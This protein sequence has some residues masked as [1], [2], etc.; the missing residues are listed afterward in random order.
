MLLL[1]V[2]LIL[3][4]CLKTSPKKIKAV[5]SFVG[6]KERIIEFLQSEYAQAERYLIEAIGQ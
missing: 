1:S 3:I 5:N 6:S 2:S 4:S